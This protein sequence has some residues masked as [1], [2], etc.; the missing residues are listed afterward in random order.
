M[1]KKNKVADLGCGEGTLIRILLKDT[2]FQRI[3]GVDNDIER[4]T[5]AV[6]KI[7]FDE[8]QAVFLKE[9]STEIKLF[10]G[11]YVKECKL[12]QR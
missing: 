8:N 2:K 4:L 5:F 9:Q 11:Q 10:K 6:N 3:S 7:K 1:F 12:T